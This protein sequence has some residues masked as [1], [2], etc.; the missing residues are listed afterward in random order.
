MKTATIPSLR[1]APELRASAEAFLTEG[2][3]LSGFVEQSIREAIARRQVRQAFIA[4]GL[5]SR[6][7]ARNSGE[8][9]SAE[10]IEG[11]LDALLRGAGEGA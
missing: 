7:A 4:R 10:D 8:Y 6:E 1:V 2:E 11:E 3:T 9:F 5:A